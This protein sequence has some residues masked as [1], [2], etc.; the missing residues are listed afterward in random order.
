MNMYFRYNAVTNAFTVPPDRAG[1]YFFSS[2]LVTDAGKYTW[3]MIKKNTEILCGFS[4]DGLNSADDGT[5][6]CSAITMANPGG[7]T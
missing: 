4:E 3:F 6:S 2:H 7:I 1:L 5:G